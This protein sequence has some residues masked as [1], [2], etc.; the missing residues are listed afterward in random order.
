[1]DLPAGEYTMASRRRKYG[2][3]AGPTLFRGVDIAIVP[4][5]TR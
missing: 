3:P 2:F 4:T 1:M 5:G